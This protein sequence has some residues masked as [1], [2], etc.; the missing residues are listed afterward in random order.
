MPG[1]ASQVLDRTSLLKLDKKTGS[2]EIEPVLII[3]TP[4][5][6]IRKLRTYPFYTRYW[7]DCC[8]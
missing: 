3:D 7:R 8:R 5:I 1:D 2:S 4:V 6:N